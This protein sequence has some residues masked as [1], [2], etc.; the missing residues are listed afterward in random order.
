M[1]AAIITRYQISSTIQN[2]Y[3]PCLGSHVSQRSSLGR[4]V[5]LRAEIMKTYT[6]GIVHEIKAES[7]EDAERQFTESIMTL[8][9][10]NDLEACISIGKPE[11]LEPEQYSCL[12]KCPKCGA[13]DEVNWQSSEH[14]GEI[15]RQSGNCGKCGAAFTET[16]E[17][18]YLYTEID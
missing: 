10:N 12:S 7:P 1:N 11:T 8:I 2:T 13:E 4:A 17:I 14:D 3:S 16:S 15:L 5:Y 18:K 6:A 9:A